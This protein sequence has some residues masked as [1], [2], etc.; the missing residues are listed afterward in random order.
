MLAHH[1]ARNE[2]SIELSPANN[3]VDGGNQMVTVSITFIILNT[4]FVIL[5]CYARSLTKATYGWDD[6]LIFASLI[7]NIASCVLTIGTSA[8]LFD[9]LYGINSSLSQCQFHMEN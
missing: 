8:L 6:Y 3:S 9:Y 5:R 1:W 2:S 7:F 4:V